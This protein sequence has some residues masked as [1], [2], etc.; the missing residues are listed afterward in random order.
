[1]AGA[2]SIRSAVEDLGVERIG[3]GVRAYEDPEVIAML[4]ERR[5]P[6]EMC[7]IS[8]S[9]T[10]VCPSI[11]AHPIKDYFRQGL[12]V[13]V[14]SDDPS[15]FSSTLT[16]EYLALTGDLDFTLDEVKRIAMNAVEASF[17]SVEDKAALKSTFQ[18]EW[19][20]FDS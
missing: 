5:I 16:D 18:S 9:K 19:A 2:D 4:K 3:H 11:K 13:T 20:A 14:N 12:L 10:G 6:L 8:N 15:M 7:V 17:L 1:M